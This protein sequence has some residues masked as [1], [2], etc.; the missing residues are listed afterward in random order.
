[1]PSSGQRQ[2]MLSGGRTAE[3]Q[4]LGGKIPSLFAKQQLNAKVTS[5]V[6]AVFP[7][8]SQQRNNL[9][10]TSCRAPRLQVASSK[11]AL[12]CVS[13][14]NYCMKMGL[15]LSA[16]TCRKAFA[17]VSSEAARE[18]RQIMTTNCRMVTG[19]IKWHTWRHC[20]RHARN[21]IRSLEMLLSGRR[22]K[23]LQLFS[24]ER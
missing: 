6:A 21:A 14:V 8:R 17:T 9:T 16:G 23:R 3:E 12:T 13:V 2:K 5:H 4:M 24:L 20:P 1:M 15:T 10:E 22:L 7:Q 18:C 19:P 11:N